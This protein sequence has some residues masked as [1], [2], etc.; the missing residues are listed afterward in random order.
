MKQPNSIRQV[1]RRSVIGTVGA[2]G[3]G[4]GIGTAQSDDD[5]SRS[6]DTQQREP[7]H[8]ASRPAN[9]EFECPDG[10]IALGT[11]EFVT[12][13]DA[14]GELLDCYFQQDDGELHVTITGYDSKDGE[15]C[16]PIAVSY[17]SESYDVGHVASFGGTDSHVDDEPDGVYE[18][19]LENPSGQQAAISLLHFCGT[20]RGT[21]G[22]AVDGESN[23]SDG[24]ETDNG[25]NDDMDDSSNSDE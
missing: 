2:V 12:I 25:S 3:I 21:D 16:E 7:G 10:M 19:E 11:F 24:D 4:T 13:E 23:G 5:P 15:D 18:S 17:E 1:S 8:E 9:Q 14:D 22:D 20:E 6:N